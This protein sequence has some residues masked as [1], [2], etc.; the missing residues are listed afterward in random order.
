MHSAFLDTNVYLHYRDFR[1]VDWPQVVGREAV[2]IVVPPIVLRELRDHSDSHPVPKVRERAGRV[3][4]DMHTLFEI[5]N[6]TDVREGVEIYIEDREP[7]VDFAGLYLNPAANDDQLIASILMHQDENPAS[8]TTLITSDSGLSLISKARRFKIMSFRTPEAYRLASELDPTQAKMKELQK[9]V[10]ALKARAPQLV[11]AYADESDRARFSMGM[12]KTALPEGSPATIDELRERYPRRRH[13]E[14][15]I[16]KSL[17]DMMGG[18][19][20]EEIHRYNRELDQFFK[21]YENYLGEILKYDSLAARSLRL[22]LCLVN[23]GTA[24]AEDIDLFIHLPDGFEVFGAE[25]YP[26]VPK[27]PRPPT[28]PLTAVELL[29]SGLSGNVSGASLSEVARPP[30]MKIQRSNSYDVEV[31][32][33]SLKHHM[34]YALDPIYIVFSSVDEAQS[35]HITYQAI[36]A[37]VAEPVEGT[38]H[39]ITEQR[40]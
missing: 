34:K 35:F 31:S 13:P 20:S 17:H 26:S 39:V 4:R 22:E 7:R 19:S 15:Q 37:N 21:K 3:L 24:P 5:G 18:I 10:L 6:P 36:A 12:K 30:R 29:T 11:L 14:G 27:A 38:I 8:D 23:K 1:E 33:G 9:E 25:G 28:R 40:S 2:R 16:E 32:V